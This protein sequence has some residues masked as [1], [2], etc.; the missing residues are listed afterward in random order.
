MFAVTITPSKYCIEHHKSPFSPEKP[1]R[2]QHCHG[3]GNRIQPSS[4]LLPLHQKNLEAKYTVHYLPRAAGSCKYQVA[5]FCGLRFINLQDLW[6]KN[7]LSFLFYFFIVDTITDIP[8]FLPFAVL[9]PAP[10]SPPS[11]PPSPPLPLPSPH[12]CLYPWVVHACSLANLFQ[13]PEGLF[14]MESSTCNIFL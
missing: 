6:N 4:L 3:Q 12:C 11:P 14:H 8:H 10:A 13:S 1:H 2:P 5:C 7:W 9:Q